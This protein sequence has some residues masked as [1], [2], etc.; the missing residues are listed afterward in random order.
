[1]N[2]DICLILE[3][4]YPYVSGGVSGWTHELIKEQP[5]KKF[6]LFCL[7]P[8]G[9]LKKLKH[10]Y[11]VP[12]NVVEIVNVE[13]QH[14]PLYKKSISKLERR[15]LMKRLH[16]PLMKLQTNASLEDLEHLLGL[17]KASGKKL[18]RETL[19]DSKEAFG[20]LCDMYEEALPTSSFLDYF[21]SWRALL[22][23]LF[24]VLTCDYPQAA[25]Y[26]S[27]CTGYAGLFMARVSLETKRPTLLAEHG[28]YTNERRIEIG[29]AE[30]LDDQQS[31][32]LNVDLRATRKSLRDFWIDSFIGYSRL[33]YQVA[34]WSITLYEGNKELQL[35]DGADPKYLKVIP[36]GIDFETYSKIPRKSEGRPTVGFIGR[37][38]PIKDLKTLIRACGFLRESVPDV[39]VWIM[40]PT[41]EDAEYYEECLDLVQH[42]GLEEVVRFLGKV[43]IK[44]Y[45]GQIDVL[46]LTSLSEAQPLVILEAGGVGVPSV[47]TDVGSCSELIFGSPTE[48]PPIGPGGAICPLASPTAVAE[49]LAKLLNDR[50]VYERCSRAIKERVDR[51]YRKEL[52]H[53]AYREMYEQ[54]IAQPKVDTLARMGARM[55]VED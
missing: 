15:R 23:G 50:K 55:P 3:G 49:A 24:S 51:Y 12:P 32:N 45:L 36:N 46:V 20:L 42:G 9:S 2:S 35:D 16:E 44:E 4:T 30:W 22:G 6:S 47:A 54:L 21:W 43:N 17:L 31:L 28:I 14:L 41:E 19:T 29:T 11:E 18:G 37:V 26:H 27:L 10:K 13:L 52:Q 53:Q 38:V 48:D 8:P 39:Q 5:D 1:M 34:E 40:G 7:V 25:C 33:A